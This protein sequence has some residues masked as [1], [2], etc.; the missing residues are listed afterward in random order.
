MPRRSRLRGELGSLLLV[1]LAAI[2]ALVLL[3]ALDGGKG[4]STTAGDG[5]HGRWQPLPPV[6]GGRQTGLSALDA[7]RIGDRVLI[8]GGASYAQDRVGGLEYDLRTERWRW[9]GDSPLGWRTGYSLVAAGGEAIVWGLTASGQPSHH[10]SRFRDG[11]R[12][13]PRDGSWRRMAPAPLRKRSLHTA[14]WTGERMLVWGGANWRGRPLADG[15]AY[16]PS[17]DSW[18]ALSQAPL[19]ARRGHAAVWT[20]ERMLVWGGHAGGRR[21][22]RFT[23]D[24]AAY[25]PASGSWQRIRRAPIRSSPDAQA[26]WTGEAMLVWTGRDVLAYFPLGDYWD[27]LPRPPLRARMGAQAAWDGQELILWGGTVGTC[28]ACYRHRPSPTGSD[29]A[30]YDPRSGRWRLL[31]TSPLPPRDR[32]VAVPIEGG[33]V[34]VWGG[35]CAGSRQRADGAIYGG[36]R[37][38]PAAGLGGEVAAA[39]R[40]AADANDME[41][42][43]PAWLPGS[44]TYDGGP[45]YVVEHEDFSGDRCAQLTELL[46]LRHE[47]GGEHPFHVWVGARCGRFPLRG[48]GGRWPPS[49]NERDYLSLVLEAPEL[50]GREREAQLVGPRIVGSAR[51]NGYR[52]LVLAVDPFPGGGLHGGHYAIVWNDGASGYVLSLHYNRG[53]EGEQPTA[54]HVRTLIRAAESMGPVG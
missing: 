7:V 36:G 18:Q 3:A 39:C 14:V 26:F 5:R 48:L 51:V 22:G 29:G 12:Y 28:G 42:R 38:D 10:R 32:H 15:A 9:M 2:A 19:R 41:V 52:A 6:Q 24:G 54:R 20:G 49:P 13:R 33:G 31:P 53:D 47:A 35:C 34:L 44:R 50:P 27:L 21:R 37:L 43:C 23:A 1:G 4:D 17:E 16:D 40:Q 11:A 25:D 46:N 8:V 45:S 30:A